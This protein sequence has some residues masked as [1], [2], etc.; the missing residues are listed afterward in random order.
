MTRIKPSLLCSIGIITVFIACNSIY[1][2]SVLSARFLRLESIIQTAPIK[3]K[4]SPGRFSESIIQ[5]A[6]MKHKDSPRRFSD[7]IQL[8]V[9]RSLNIVNLLSGQ[10]ISSWIYEGRKPMPRYHVWKNDPKE[11]MLYDPKDSAYMKN[12]DTLFVSYHKIEEFTS[13]FLPHIK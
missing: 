8:N 2:S 9:D 12:N 10:H 1:K 13:D 3:H 4:D 7:N 5:T 11:K 6:P